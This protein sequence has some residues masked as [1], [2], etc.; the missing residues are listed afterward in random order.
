MTDLPDSAADQTASSAANYGDTPVDDPE[1]AAL[2]QRQAPAGTSPTS[3]PGVD[4][5]PVL[6]LT[7][8]AF[9]D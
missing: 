9:H 4:T 7:G 8:A 5:V 2:V 6:P 3:E 1:L